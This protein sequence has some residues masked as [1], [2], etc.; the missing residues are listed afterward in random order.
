M[1][2]D[3]SLLSSGVAQDRGEEDS[4]DLAQCGPSKGVMLCI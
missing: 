4:G 2:R 1:L 3:S